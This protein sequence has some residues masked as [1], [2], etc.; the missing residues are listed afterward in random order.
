MP[1]TQQYLESMNPPR[2]SADP[3]IMLMGGAVMLLVGLAL[4]IYLGAKKRSTKPALAT[5]AHAQLWLGM[6]NAAASNA[7]SAVKASSR[8]RLD[9]KLLKLLPSN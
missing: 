2:Y 7:Q 3:D 5:L 6:T 9:P 4:L 1:I 8:V